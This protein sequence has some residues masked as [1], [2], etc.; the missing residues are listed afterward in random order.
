[1]DPMVKNL[2]VFSARFLSLYLLVMIVKFLHKVFWMPIR[3]Q[4]ALRS[5]GIK[6]PSYKF[7]HGNIKEISDMRK[8]SM[9]KPMDHLSHE[10]F[11]RLMPH[12]HSWVKLY[13]RN[14]L[15]WHGPQ[16]QLV[17]TE[18]ELIK[19]IMNN[20]DGA[21]PKL[22]LGRY[23]KKLLGD[24]LSSTEGA[25]W[26]KLRKLANGVFHGESLKGM[27]PAMITST[28]NML[29]KWKERKGEEI[30]VFEEFRLLTS[31]VISKTAFGSSYLEGQKIFDMMMKMAKIIARNMNIV[32]L[33]VISNM[34]KNKDD[35]ASD[36]LEQ[37]IKDCVVEIIR[38]KDQQD[39]MDAS[40]SDYLGELIKA[41]HD[42]DDLKR[43]FLD[44]IVDEC[45]TFYFA[46]HETTTV[47]LGWTIF[48]LASHQEWQEKAREEV[49]QF[50]G[51]A[52]P[53][54]DSITRLKIMNMILEESFRLYPPVILV[55]R[56]VSRE[57]RLRNMTLPPNTELYISP[58]AVHHDPKIWGNDVHLFKPDRFEGGIAKATNN[59]P[60]AFMPFG[61][62][63]RI[64]VG[65]NFAMAEAKIALAMILQRFKFKL[66]PNYVHSPI[67]V[68]MVKPQHGVQ[69]ILEAI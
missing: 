69:I 21:Y 56:K 11:P 32:Q 50:F 10:I 36:K 7:L 18:A 52:N 30:E 22:E 38:K 45:K 66:S 37:G 41:S 14:F 20:K 4:Y 53:D 64:C 33:P 12:V 2:A 55:K 58:L 63:P 60:A 27:I 5:Q 1:M 8:Q 15:Y 48:L 24:G 39:I 9:G 57:V 46:G 43:I 51:Q 42:K 31:E 44:D 13:G 6:G 49:F 54:Q 67:Q 3:M 25:K 16:P 68:I 40:I 35:I 34:I 26:V 17:V 61:F 19:E 65:S 29:Q 59:T 62:G 47:L 23:A 28:E